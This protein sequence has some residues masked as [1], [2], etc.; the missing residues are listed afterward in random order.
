[1]ST[2]GGSVWTEIDANYFTDGADMI[3]DAISSGTVWSS[4]DRNNHMAVSK[5]TNWGSS[6]SRNELS[7]LIG[8]TYTLAI[9]PD[10]NNTVYAGGYENSLP[11]IYRTTNGG[12]SWSKLTAS[13]LTGY[14]W[15][16]VIDPD[17]TSIIYAA[18]ESGI[19]KSTNSGSSFS[20]IS[21]SIGYTKCLFM[22]PD[23]NTVIYAATYGQGI[24]MTDNAGS[25]WQEM[26]AGLDEILTT[27]ISLNP[28]TWLFCGS[29]GRSVLR[30][31]IEVGIGEASGAPV[32]EFILHASPNPVLGAVTIQCMISEAG[33]VRMAIYDVTGRL[34][35]DLIDG[36][37]P[38]GVLNLVWNAGEEAA[39]GVYFLV[40]S[41]GESVYT[42]RLAVIR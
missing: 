29:E 32:R 22:D 31:D 4:G 27:S 15:D 37:M 19:Y 10:L 7:T 20:K 24:W 28:D 12:T 1:M 25:T 6:W 16:L 33:E 21:G 11:A 17:D 14:I 42:E 39:P 36:T 13:G 38:S 3:L 5:S 35:T 18:T 26:N 8:K 9:D 30:Y 40:L 41:T 23:D 34:V 2:D